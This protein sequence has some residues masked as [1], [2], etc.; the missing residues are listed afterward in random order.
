M[1]SDMSDP[2]PVT[3][4]RD[5][6]AVVAGMVDDVL[7]LVE[8]WPAWDGEPAAVDDRLYTPHKAVRRVADP[9]TWSTT[10]P[11]SRP[12]WPACPRSPTGGTPR[13]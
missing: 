6:A 5:P 4:E 13:R 10:S 1:I 11:R 3:D 8:T 9:T 7:R 2:R 12:G